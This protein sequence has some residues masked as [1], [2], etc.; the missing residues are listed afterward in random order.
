MGWGSA[1]GLFDEA[2]KVALDFAPH[3]PVAL[4]E[5][6]KGVPEPIVKAVVHQMYTR[7]DWDDWDTQDESQFFEPY[8]REVMIELGEIDPDEI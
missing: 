4:A 5:E 8:L 2:V 1:T 7:V 6:T 3:I